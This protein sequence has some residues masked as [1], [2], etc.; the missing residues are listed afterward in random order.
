MQLWQRACDTNN[1]GSYGCGDTKFDA[2][3][4]A[5]VCPAG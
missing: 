1:D 4:D 3:D 2:S 5:G